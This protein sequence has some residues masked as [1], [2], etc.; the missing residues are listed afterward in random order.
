MGAGNIR[1]LAPMAGICDADF[2]IKLIPYGFEMV[3]LGGYNAD[4][5]TALAG[6]RIIERGRPEFDV[7]FEE[8]PAII[9]AEA[10][11]IKRAFDVKVSVNLRALDPDK[12]LEISRLE[13]VDVVELNAHCRQPEITALGAGQAMLKDLEFLEDYTLELI[14]KARST[15]SVKLR[16]NVDG[17]DDVEVCK[18]L[19][20][21]GCDYIHLDAM[22]PG[23]DSAD[24]DLVRR[25]SGSINNS[26]LIGNNSIRDLD[27]ARAMLEAGAHGISIA[28]AAIKGKLD[29]NLNDLSKFKVN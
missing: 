26:T 27:S 12:V 23:V 20:S 6:R 13:H 18:L 10:L 15:V 28:R 9:Q 22:K 16:A 21:V 7:D 24:L 25:V 2:C 4:R 8:L 14:N 17:V 1:V 3:T 11:K 29:F 5:E 19:D